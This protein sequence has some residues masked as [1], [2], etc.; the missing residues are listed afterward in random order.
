MAVWEAMILITWVFALI[1]SIPAGIIIIAIVGGRKKI[2]Q[3]TQK[4]KLEDDGG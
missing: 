2:A 4:M 3:L 1:V